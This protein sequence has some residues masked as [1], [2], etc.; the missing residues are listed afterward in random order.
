MAPSLEEWPTK[1]K[2][3]RGTFSLWGETG[4]AGHQDSILMSW[5][6]VWIYLKTFC[7]ADISQPFWYIYI[8]IYIYKFGQQ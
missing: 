5:E 7:S 8:Y 1:A 6:E 3:E 4:P 2:E